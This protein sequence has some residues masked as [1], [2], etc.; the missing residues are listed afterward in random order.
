MIHMG[1]VRIFQFQAQRYMALQF[2]FSF[3]TA[4]AFAQGTPNTDEF[5]K[6]VDFLPPAPNAAAIAKAGIFS[7][8][9]NIGAPSVNVPLYT[10]KGRKLAVNI[11]LI[12][13]TNGIKVD[14]IA[15]R[16]GMGWALNAGGVITR[17]VR[18]G[19]D[20]RLPRKYPWSTTIGNNWATYDYMK[21]VA[22]S[23][24]FTGVDAQP[25]LFNF[26]FD[27]ISGSFVLDG[28]MNVVQMPY[29]NLKIEY[30]FAA[31]AAWNFRITT[32]NGIRYFFGGGNATEK[33]K[34]D[35]SC[36]K[37]FD[38][39]IAT[40][41]YLKKIEHS[42]GDVINFS[43]NSL[44][45]TYDNGVSES[46]ELV[47][48]NIAIGGNCNFGISTPQ[49]ISSNC[50]NYTRTQ[51]YYLTD[52]ASSA[53]SVHLTYTSRSDCSDVLLLSVEVYNS[54]NGTNRI[55]KF[56]LS[57]LN[58]NSV[59]YLSMITDNSETSTDGIY[60][61][62]GYNDPASRPTRLSKSQDHW[63]YYNGRN[64]TTL[65]PPEP[66]L[67][68]PASF[69]YYYYFSSLVYADRSA[70]FQY[71]AKGML[72]RILYPTG[73]MDSIMYEPNGASGKNYKSAPTEYTCEVTGASVHDAVTKNISF[74]TDGWQNVTLQIS[75]ICNQA[76]CNDASHN[77]GVLSVD[78][79]A[80]SQTYA[81]GTSTTAYV[82]LSQ[83][84][85]TLSLQANGTAVTTRVKLIYNAPGDLVYVNDYVGG[86]R[87]KA[88]LTGNPH[89][90]PLYKRYYYGYL[91]NLDSSSLL[92][93]YGPVY[94]N[95]Y[96]SRDMTI[97]DMGTDKSFQQCVH[98]HTILYSNSL[99]S[100]F[101]YASGL[102][103]YRSVIE[104]IGENFEG[105][106][107]ATTFAIS[108][109]ELGTAVWGNDMQDA[110]MN[111]HSIAYNGKAL[112]EQVLK[113]GAN[114]TLFPVSQ[115]EYIYKE[116]ERGRRTVTGYSVFRKNN[117]YFDFDT[118]CNSTSQ[119]PGTNYSCDYVRSKMLLSFDMMEYQVVSPWIYLDTLRETAYDNAG[120]NP[121]V[122]IT[123]MYYENELHQQVTRTETHNS[124]QELITT[125]NKYPHDYASGSN[126]YAQM[127]ANNI[128]APVVDSKSWKDTAVTAEVRTNFDNWGNGNFAPASVEKAYRNNLLEIEGAIISYDA[129][130]NVTEFKG[131]DGI[132]NAIIYAYNYHYPVAKVSGVTYAQAVAQLTAGVS[133]LQTMSETQLRTELDYL[134]TGLPGAFV[135]VYTYQPN[136]GVNS[137]TD[138]NKN[139][140]YFEYDG[141]GRLKLVRD[142]NSNILKTINY[143]YS[144]PDGTQYYR[145]FFSDVQSQFFTCQICPSGTMGSVVQYTVPAKTYF[146]FTS[147]E[148]A[149]V[150]ALADLQANGQGYANGTGYCS[151]LMCTGQGYATINCNCEAGQIY[152]VSCSD[153]SDGTWVQNYKYKWSD[154]S[155]STAVYSRTLPACTG[156]DKKKVN[157]N[158]LTGI[159]V[160]TATYQNANGTWTCVYHYHWTDGSNSTNLSEISN[161]PCGD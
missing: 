32:A 93:S 130:G 78:G 106:G 59:P 19:P 88:L 105:G 82:G 95:R 87:V 20:E 10:L 159:K 18:G 148:E 67:T 73:G 74:T 9:K 98:D 26:N 16:V 55:K 65:L 140:S 29:G 112:K 54:I 146:S 68:D 161:A 58:S 2:F 138:N 123:K 30:D 118:T 149:N 107:T 92:Q 150:K 22:S 66:S 24:N 160:Y 39:Y 28:D 131:R 137:I 141:F 132:T 49:L 128:I 153:N 13:A 134:Y 147:T 86:V 100:L 48:E 63:G 89:E 38:A 62:F 61:Q 79:T 41:W 31:N 17:I 35:Q 5:R 135:T 46:R 33:T 44:E 125:V 158:C 121:L 142:K 113:K 47:T 12:Y 157:C 120:Q 43:Y 1:T 14:E 114:G 27:G 119:A 80:F 50:I 94:L 64:N 96:Q 126:V 15:S 116:D 72:T 144:G 56:S 71:A 40:S 36:G 143:A 108:Q 37:T 6:M 75:I 3:L 151:N 11:G 127:V 109:D 155:L 90:R 110:P 85:H 156:A 25:D 60:Y 99:R 42:T 69:T 139:T 7:L 101:S 53:G 45:Y 83:G 52:I 57:Y 23:D 77:V 115:T 81:A 34:R 76:E 117:I 70:D 97:E 103:S 4:G 21:L 84:T 111:N 136:V 124:K 154:N 152:P 133:G 104:S 91:E 102:V 51:G 129:F 122:T 145:L 8:N